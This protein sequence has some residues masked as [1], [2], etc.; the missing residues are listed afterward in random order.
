MTNTIN[1]AELAGIYAALVNKHTSIASDSACSLSQIRKQLLFPEMQRNHIHDELLRQIVDL[2][3][4]SPNPI[5]FYKVKA[6]E[7]IAGNEFAD[8][9]AKHAALHDHGHTLQLQP[10]SEDGSPYTKKHWIAT[11]NI[12]TRYITGERILIALPNLKKQA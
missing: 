2:I 12:E 7:G 1:R 6:H 8:A 4:A 9:I 3:K 11:R 5:Y 10:V